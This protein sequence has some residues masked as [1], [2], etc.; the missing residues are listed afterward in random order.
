MICRDVTDV[1]Q[2]WQQCV[3]MKSSNIKGWLLMFQCMYMTKVILNEWMIRVV[4]A[5]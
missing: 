1:R 5:V 4:K 3:Y 2:H